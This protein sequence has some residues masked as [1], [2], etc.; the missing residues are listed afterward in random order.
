MRNIFA[1]QKKEEHY[2][3]IQEPGSLYIGHVSPSSGSSND[4]A[5]SIISYLSTHNIPIDELDVI[6]CD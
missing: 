1:G 6:G 3:L 5:S 2:S 4:I